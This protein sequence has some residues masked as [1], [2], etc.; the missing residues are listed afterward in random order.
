MGQPKQRLPRLSA[1]FIE[2]T[3]SHLSQ[4]LAIYPVSLYHRNFSLI[5]RGTITGLTGCSD[6]AGD[7]RVIQSFQLPTRE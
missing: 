3:A 1:A 7:I 5:L 6:G 4:S 2:L